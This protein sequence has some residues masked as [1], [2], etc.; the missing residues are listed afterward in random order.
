MGKPTD[1]KEETLAGGTTQSLSGSAPRDPYGRL[2]PLLESVALSKGQILY[3][4]RG[5][6]EYAY[7][8]SGAR[9]AFHRAGVRLRCG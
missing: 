2:A 6:I 3:E 4:A 8:A 1:G 5:P 9:P 7:V